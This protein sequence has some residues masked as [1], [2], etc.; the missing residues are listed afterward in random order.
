V[1]YFNILVPTGDTVRYKYLLKKLVQDK[2][3]V[4]ISGETGVGKSVIIGDFLGTL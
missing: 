2:K 1:P 4:L 3:N